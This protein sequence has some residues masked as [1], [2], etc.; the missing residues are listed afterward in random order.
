MDNDG[1]LNDQDGIKGQLKGP[2][3]IHINYE[4]CIEHCF[5]A[6]SCIYAVHP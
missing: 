1:G 6:P 5:L 4:I 3:T 2:S